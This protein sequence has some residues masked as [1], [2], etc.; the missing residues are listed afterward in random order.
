MLVR[1]V[2]V[3]NLNKWSIFIHFV[4]IHFFAAKNPHKITKTPYFEG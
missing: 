3:G 4:A 1:R 2:F